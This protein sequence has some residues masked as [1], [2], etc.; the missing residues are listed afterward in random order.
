MWDDSTWPVLDGPFVAFEGVG[1]GQSLR[2]LA[3]HVGSR[4]GSRKGSRTR[5]SEYS[6]LLVHSARCL[7][8]AGF[9]ARRH[10]PNVREC[11]RTNEPCGSS[12]DVRAIRGARTSSRLALDIVSSPT[13]PRDGTRPA[14]APAAGATT[15]QRGRPCPKGVGDRVRY[16]M[17]RPPGLVS[18]GACIRTRFGARGGVGMS[19]PR[20]DPGHPVATRLLGHVKT[21]ECDIHVT[22]PQCLDELPQ[23]LLCPSA[24]R[25]LWT[26]STDGSETMVRRASAINIGRRHWFVGHGIL[27]QI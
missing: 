3:V 9:R 24:H 27:R 20:V 5:K 4:K 25:A 18:P 14:N 15:P 7:E 10:G 22:E 23:T 19:P 1:Y 16:T 26:L 13:R 11:V 6:P 8:T 21:R 17:Y 12:L 2:R